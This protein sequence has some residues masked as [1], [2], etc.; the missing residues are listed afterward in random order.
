ML[1]YSGYNYGVSDRFTVGVRALRLP[2]DW[3]VFAHV[4]W[5]VPIA[6]NFQV[7]AG[8]LLGGGYTYLHND[9]PSLQYHLALPY[10]ALTI[11][12]R[13]KFINFTIAKGLAD[14]EGDAELSPWMYGISAAARAG[15]RLRLFAEYGTN[16][17]GIYGRMGNYGFTILGRKSSLDI[18]LF[19][20]P[21]YGR[22]PMLAYTNR[23]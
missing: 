3:G 18:G 23:F 10:A 6:H 22:L 9:G 11:G 7:G 16:E 15:N 14:E 5:A 19:S 4:K 21:N 2:D 20:S 17:P 8:S 13:D 12:N 1:V